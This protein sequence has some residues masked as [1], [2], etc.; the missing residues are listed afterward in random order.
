MPG[1]WP[2]ATFAI[3]VVGSLLLGVMVALHTESS[4]SARGIA[5][6]GVGFCGGF[7]TFSTF[8]VEGL[9]LLQAGKPGLAAL[10]VAASCALGVFAAWLGWRLVQLNQ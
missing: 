5:L 6:L 8:S 2:W 9:H 7:T 4:L 1:E 10:Y 3:N